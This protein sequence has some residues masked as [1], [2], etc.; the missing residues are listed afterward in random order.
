MRFTFTLYYT[1]IKSAIFLHLQTKGPARKNVAYPRNI[2]IDY[3]S[4]DND[5]VNLPLKRNRGPK[6]EVCNIPLQPS[7]L[8]AMHIDKE[9]AAKKIYK[10]PSLLL[11]IDNKKGVFVHSIVIACHTIPYLHYVHVSSVTTYH[12]SKKQPY[13]EAW[14]LG[15]TLLC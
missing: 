6:Q 9:A 1:L 3:S 7:C 14:T 2:D 11:I 12:I 5:F 4:D 10:V 15:I 13:A 8:A